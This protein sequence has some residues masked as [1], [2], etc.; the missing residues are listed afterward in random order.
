MEKILILLKKGEAVYFKWRYNMFDKLADIERRYVELSEQ[1]NDPDIIGDNEKWRKLMKEHGDITPIIE[2][3]N[4]YKKVKSDIEE[5]EQML[6]EE[7]DDEF[8]QLI[9]EEYNEN[10]KRIEE[11]SKQ[12]TLLL[13]PKDPNDDKN[14]IV[15]IRGGAGGDEAAIF[16]GDLFR[17]YSRY[18]EGRR[19]KT[20]NAVVEGTRLFE[21]IKV[22]GGLTDEA[23]TEQ[24]N[25]AEVVVDGQKVVIPSFEDNN[26]TAAFGSSGNIGGTGEPA[27]LGKDSQGRININLADSSVLQEIPGVGPATAEKIIAYREENGKFSQIEDIK[28]VSG[29]GNK[30][31]QKMK[32]KITV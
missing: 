14:V 32:D 30:T 2:K 11:I 19:W 5:A 31:F 16:A 17:M 3:Y 4:E 15:E 18:A 9:K 25:Q 7:T 8:K 6:S 1:I 23:F 27:A 26:G 24:I 12:L 10:K 29:I 13:L 21:V 22:A 28:M 20:E